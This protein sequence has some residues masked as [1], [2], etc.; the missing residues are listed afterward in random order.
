MKIKRKCEVC[1]K[2][3]EVYPCRVKNQGA[4]YCSN[5]CQRIGVGIK[6]SKNY[7]HQTFICGHCGKE[8]KRK[9]SVIMK[10]KI[11]Y[12][13]MGCMAKDYKNRMSGKKNPNYKDGRCEDI[14]KYNINFLKQ[15]KK[16]DPKFRLRINIGIQIYKAIRSKKSGR[17]WESLVEYTLKDL[18]KHIEK[19]FKPGMTWDN[20]G[21]WHIDHIIPVAVFNFTKPEHRDF[22]RC[23]ALK[24]L[25]PL[26][27]EDNCRKQ[28]KL[29]K[30]FQ[31]SLQL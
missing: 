17:S 19:Q 31:P 6:R 22:K 2:I 18:T 10:N 7:K 26:W 5:K 29:E 28:A 8:T 4:K 23:W 21:E 11:N 15:K 14:I 1:N 20:Y 13:S 27:G 24:N 16:N 9:P 25:Q 30:H 12:C 3:F